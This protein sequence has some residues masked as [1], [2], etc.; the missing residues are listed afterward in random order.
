[1][2]P[3][4]VADV[5]FGGHSAWRRASSAPRPA[6]ASLSTVLAGYISDTFGSGTAF[7]GLAAVAAVGLTVI[8]L[9]MPET[10][11]TA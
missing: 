10:R 11:R 9:F 6:S 7:V 3:P 1:M 8:W 4:I 2:V 5:S